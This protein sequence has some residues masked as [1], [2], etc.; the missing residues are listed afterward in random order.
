MHDIGL[1]TG[2]HGGVR[3]RDG[4]EFQSFQDSTQWAWAAAVILS[5]ALGRALETQPRARLLLSGGRTPGPA[6]AALARA[7]L[8]WDRI[9][10]ALVDERWLLPD[11]PDSNARMVRESL[12]TGRAAATRF[13]SITRAGRGIEE[14]VTIANMH[15][16]QPASVVVLGMGEDGHV[17]SLF[18][19]MIGLADALASRRPYVAV[20]ASGC[21]GAGSWTRR[22][23]LTPAGLAPAGTRLLLIR[24]ARKR[25]LLDRVL[26]ADNAMEFP[27]RIAF[28][29][30]GATLRIL[31][32]P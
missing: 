23:S 5:A 8:P 15:A 2:P 13:E 1:Q 22:V 4:V 20:D 7:P 14:A 18:P 3:L 12:L 32:C 31:W 21:P 9:D 26:A 27:A 19:G 17:A 29:T 10:V 16:S 24:G 25:E 30:P 28:T 6:Y 11:D